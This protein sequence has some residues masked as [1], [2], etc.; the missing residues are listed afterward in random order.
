MDNL[1]PIATSTQ[2]YSRRHFIRFTAGTCATLAMARTPVSALWQEK[3]PVKIGLIADLHHDVMHDGRSRMM[4][5]VEEMSVQKPDAMMQLGDFAYPN[6]KNKEVIDLFNNA[7][8]QTLHV[9]GNHDTDSG[10][11]KEQCIKIWGMSGRYYAHN[12][13]GLQ[14]LVLDGNDPGSPTH[15]GGYPSY[16]GREQ[17]DWLVGQLSAATDPVIVCSHQPLAGAWAVDNAAE[18]QGILG[19]AADKVLMAI[20]GHSHIDS[21]LRIRNVPYLHVNSAS[22]QWVGGDFQHQSFSDEVHAGHPWISY[23]C[24]YRDPLFAMLTV[25]FQAQTISIEGRESVWMGPSPAQL[26]RDLD[27]TLTNGEEVAPRIRDR[28]IEKVSG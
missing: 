24:P 10:H 20:N 7:H 12:V 3:A 25:D 27:P 9:I 15:K 16:I 28:T 18:V 2:K 1:P 26:G 17:L 23:T 13:G 19:E 8:R 14:L 5:F 21:L 4:A 11:T 6:D 22:Y